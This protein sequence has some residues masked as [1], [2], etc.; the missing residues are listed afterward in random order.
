MGMQRLDLEHELRLVGIGGQAGS[1]LK[2][3]VCM[4]VH[5]YNL[6]MCIQ[7]RTKSER[8]LQFV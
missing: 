3:C 8:Q 2:E 4:C 7:D 5:D 6:G 1:T